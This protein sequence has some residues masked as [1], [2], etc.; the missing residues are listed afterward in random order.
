MPFE[1][2]PTIFTE[3]LYIIFEFFRYY[4]Y[5]LF[6]FD[7]IRGSTIRTPILQF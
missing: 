6:F 2:G 1:L 7:D 5:V 4:H 3:S